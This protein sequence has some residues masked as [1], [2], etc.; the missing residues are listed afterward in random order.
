VNDDGCKELEH[1]GRKATCEPEKKKKR[2]KKKTPR[3]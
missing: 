3:K 1:G 2:K